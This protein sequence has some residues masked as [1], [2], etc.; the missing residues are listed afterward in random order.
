MKSCY[1]KIQ[2]WFR[3]TTKNIMLLKIQVYGN[4]MTCRLVNSNRRFGG[5]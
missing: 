4:V 1:V 3:K 2:H 5:S